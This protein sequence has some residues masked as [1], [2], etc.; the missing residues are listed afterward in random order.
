M[1]E[2]RLPPHPAQR[3]NRGKP[4]TFTFEGRLIQAYEGETVAA[5]LYA[6]G[7][8]IF[9]RSFKYHRPRGLLCVAGRC[10]NCLMEVD[11]IPNV[12]TCM[13]PARQGMRVRGQHAWPSLEH[14]LFACF[15]KLDRVLPVG[16]YYKTFIHPTW[17]WPTYEKVLRHLAGLGRLDITREPDGHGER[18]HLHA[19][20]AIV[21]GGPAGI[22]AALEAA[23]VGVEALLI[24]DEPTLGGHLQWQL[25]PSDGK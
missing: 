6:A 18:I 16:F 8:R 21:G 14:D 23:R 10:P 15:D 12:R 4:L 17:L 2:S 1:S 25:L 19:D 24:D 11:G 22:A 9:S 3:V 7:V 13:E 20:V 5:A